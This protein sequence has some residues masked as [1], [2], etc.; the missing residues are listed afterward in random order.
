MNLETI[1]SSHI[2]NLDEVR[3]FFGEFEHFFDKFF[4][5]RFLFERNVKRK[6]ESSEEKVNVLENKESYTVVTELPGVLIEDLELLLQ[7][8]I[9]SIKGMRKSELEG[10]HQKNEK[11]YSLFSEKVFLGDAINKQKIE[12]TFV[13]GILKIYLLKNKKRLNKIH[14]IKIK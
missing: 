12:A 4:R 6:N 2:H 13:D 9:L 14:R 11:Q 10:S 8:N 3:P 7:N 1:N 5:K